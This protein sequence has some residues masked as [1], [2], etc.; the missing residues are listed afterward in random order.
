[1]SYDDQEKRRLMM[2]LVNNFEKRVVAIKDDED[3]VRSLYNLVTEEDFK[4]M[5]EDYRKH[6][7][8][9]L[10]EAELVMVQDRRNG[11]QY[12]CT[13]K[14]EGFINATRE[15]VIKYNKALAQHNLEP[16]YDDTF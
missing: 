7:E 1:M 15:H 14:Y 3:M 10:K 11:K 2:N 6:L 8:V 9:L 5:F 12:Y 4:S 16:V 13:L